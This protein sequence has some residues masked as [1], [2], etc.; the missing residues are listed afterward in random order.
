MTIYVVRHAKAGDRSRWEGPD[1]L[2]PLSGKGRRQADRLA[3]LLSGEGV[4]RVLSSPA[5]R[6]RQT[7]EPLATRL[8]LDVEVFE[9]LAE[10]GAL[11]DTLRLLEK[12]SD[13]P[14]VLCSHGDVIGAL[15]EH[16]ADST[17]PLDGEVRYPKGSVWRLDVRDGSIVGA[18][19]LAPPA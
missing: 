7:V 4:R 19:Y 2:R 11:V 3:T 6:C 15:V 5:L 18:T 12:V 17:V 10:G 1:A 13:A 14:S 9:G 16:L 8:A